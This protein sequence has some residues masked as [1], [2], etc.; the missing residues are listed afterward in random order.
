MATKKKITRKELKKPDEFVSTTT[1]IYQYILRNWKFFASGLVVI[2][3]LMGVGFMWH[4][5][6]IRKEMAAFSLYHN[7]QIEMHKATRLRKTALCNAWDTLETKYPDTPAAV[8]GLLQK[9]SCLLEHG[10]KEG[11]I[12]TVQKLLSDT[13]L[14]KVVKILSQLMKGYALEER[15]AYAQAEKVFANLLRDP[16]DFLKDTVRYH[17]YICQ[18]RQ[19]K[20]NMAKKTLSELKVNGNSDFALPVILVKIQ[21]ARLGITQ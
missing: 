14:P 16:D 6:A 1:E 3:I 10:S 13:K 12:E 9:S 18:L 17:L 19:G 8:Y 2:A 21:K 11:C 15:R 5:H 20:K 4:R 7:I